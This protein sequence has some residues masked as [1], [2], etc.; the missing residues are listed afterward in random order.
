MIEE[1]FTTEDG[2]GAQ[3]LDQNQQIS[4]LLGEGVV[5]GGEIVEGADPLTVDST[6][7]TVYIDGAIH[8]LGAVSTSLS[9]Y[10]NPDQPRKAVLYVDSTGDLEVAA[11]VPEDP[12][13]ED[14]V[15]FD[16]YR[17][18]PPDLSQTAAI[19]L[20]EVWIGAGVERITDQDLRDRRLNATLDAYGIDVIE[21]AINKL[22]DGSGTTHTG[23]LADASDVRS[24]GDIE[25]AINDDADHGSSAQHDYFSGSHSDLTVVTET[26]HH[27]PPSPDDFR[28]A[29][30]G[31][32]DAA[33]LVGSSGA[34]G[35]HLATDGTTLAWTDPP[36]GQASVLASGTVTHTGGSATDVF[37]TDVSDDQFA[38]LN[39][40]YGVASDPDWTG[41]YAFNT[42][43]G[44]EWDD[45][46]NQLDLA[47][48][49]AWDTDPGEGN[50]IDIEYVVYDTSP[51]VVQGTYNDAR[52]V[53][54]MSGAAIDPADVVASEEL[55][56]PVYGDLNDY[57]SPEIGDIAIASGD[58]VQEFGQYLFNGTDWTGPFAAGVSGLSG[59]SIDT[60]KSW[61]GYTMTDLA[62]PVGG[63]SPVRQQ[64]FNDHASDATVHHEP[65]A[66]SDIDHANIQNVQSDQ[67]HDAYTRA[68]AQGATAGSIISVPLPVA[69]IPD[70]NAY[71]QFVRVGSGETFD[72]VRAELR[73]TGGG[74]PSGLSAEVVDANGTTQYSQ[75]SALN[76]GS[77]ESSLTSVG[78]D[79]D[80]ELRID[81]QTGSLQT[82]SALFSYRVD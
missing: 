44:R 7:A 42:V 11:G 49:I 60:Q 59:L 21:A 61:N 5:S 77:V 24:D 18:A 75:T 12:Q 3:A 70:T 37:L 25:Q 23:E 63:T 14:E 53:G 9:S 29:V 71:R 32:V 1:T 48:T 69:D 39:V 78:S 74:V 55:R 76:E 64:E 58:G 82:A 16:T 62:A 81:N 80:L 73:V 66:G 28:D 20:A 41:N 30:T 40:S 72:L 19:P 65:T 47:A 46:N 10:V 36:S 33:D 15:R 17:P 56:P 8:E 35:Q 38:T 27:T 43:E 79:T 45:E 34:N 67:H 13:P 50:D 54:A 68:D 26:D 52:A 2:H 4:Q 57:P 6:A 22:T 51:A 31:E